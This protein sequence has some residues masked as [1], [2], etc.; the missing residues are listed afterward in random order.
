MSKAE[1]IYP[2][3]L[4]LQTT[5]LL[6]HD[7]AESLLYMDVSGRKRLRSENLLLD[8]Q[9]LAEAKNLLRG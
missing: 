9:S 3:V 4:L 1:S 8:A 5:G 7:A 2:A 6:R